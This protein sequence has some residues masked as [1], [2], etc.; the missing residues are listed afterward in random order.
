MQLVLPLEIMKREY[1]LK[2]K[3]VILLPAGL[4]T[5]PL[6]SYSAQKMEMPHTIPMY[7]NPKRYKCSVVLSFNTHKN[8][9]RRRLKFRTTIDYIVV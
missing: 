7:Y 1:F 6:N 3:I 2:T 8:L 5:M 9:K 4:T